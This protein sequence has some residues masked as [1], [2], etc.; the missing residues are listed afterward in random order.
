M[1][2]RVFIGA[3][4]SPALAGIVN[5]WQQNWQNLPVRWLTPEQLHI[6]VVPPW[7]ERN[8]EE[9]MAILK[10]LTVNPQPIPVRFT[11][12]SFGP[13]PLA[14]RLIWAEGLAPP[15]LVALKDQ[16]EQTLGLTPLR[17]P[18]TLHLTLARFRPEDFTSFPFHHLEEHVNWTDTLN[19]FALIESFL[20]PDGVEYQT[21][22]TYHLK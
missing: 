20:K 3:K 15:E 6:T 1:S 21:L 13:S 17:R 9:V 8:A 22:S 2:R 5:V 11:K 18:F 19:S 12:V 16:L 4:P 10:P 7:N 14:P